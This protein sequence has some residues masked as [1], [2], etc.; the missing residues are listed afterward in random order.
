MSDLTE[1]LRT[2][3]RPCSYSSCPTCEQ[4]KWLAADRIEELESAL[5]EAIGDIEDWASYADDYFKDKHDLAGDLA[6]HRR[7]LGDNDAGK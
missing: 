3:H 5:R 2:S 4:L 1:R 7:A 6:K